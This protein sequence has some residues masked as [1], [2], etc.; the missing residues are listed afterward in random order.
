MTIVKTVQD[1]FLSTLAFPLGGPCTYRSL[2]YDL[3]AIKSH[4]LLRLE[5][6]SLELHA[7]IDGMLRCAESLEGSE[8]PDRPV[9]EKWAMGLLA[10]DQRLQKELGLTL[11]HC[12]FHEATYF[13]AARRDPFIEELFFWMGKALV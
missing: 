10:L 3:R 8:R 5:P 12:S 2:I 11:P 6:F 9:L 7:W 1:S 13:Q 4:H